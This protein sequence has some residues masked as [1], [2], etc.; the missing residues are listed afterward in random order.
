MTDED[1]YINIISIV[2][3]CVI[4]VFNLWTLKSVRTRT[5]TEGKAAYKLV[6]SQ[7]ILYMISN[8]G[9][10]VDSSADLISDDKKTV[11]NIKI[12]LIFRTLMWLF[13]EIG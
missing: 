7:T 9:L 11:L 6:T 3:G 13:L 2:V 1:L 5:D 10:I 8:F 4:L 12:Q